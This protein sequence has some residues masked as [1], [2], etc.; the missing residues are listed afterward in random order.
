MFGC[1]SLYC[2]DS[3]VSKLGDFTGRIPNCREVKRERT[4]MLSHQRL[5]KN[6][7]QLGR[8]RSKQERRTFALRIFASRE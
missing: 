4:G 7:S 6:T 8:R 1:F 3:M 5:L 2:D